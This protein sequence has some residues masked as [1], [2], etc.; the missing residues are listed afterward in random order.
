M[1]PSPDR[2]GRYEIPHELLRFDTLMDVAL[3][4]LGVYILQA[5]ISTNVRDLKPRA[6]RLRR[7]SH[8]KPWDQAPTS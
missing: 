7:A 1:R 6:A 3:I 5:F 8:R 2:L 4:V